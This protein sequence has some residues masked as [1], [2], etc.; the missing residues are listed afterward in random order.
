MTETIRV[1]WVAAPYKIHLYSS[2]ARFFPRNI[3]LKVV[4]AAMAY[5]G[6][7]PLLNRSKRYRQGIWFLPRRDLLRH[8][9]EFHPDVVFTDYPAYPSW[10]ARLYSYLSE[11]KVPLV[12]WLLGDFWTEYY[13]LLRSQ[14]LRDRPFVR[15]YLFTWATGLGLSNRVLTVC[16]WLK[17]RAEQR[18]PRKRISVQYQGVDPELWL[19]KDGT[20]YD[21]KRPAVGILQDNNIRP[22]V[23]GMLRFVEVLK[24]MPDVNFYVAGGGAYT[25]LVEKAFSGLPNAHLV[26]RVPY[27]DGVRRFY[28]SCDLYALPSGLDCCPTTLLEASLNSLP[29]VASRVGGIPELVREGETGWTV[30]N[31]RT[32]EWVAKI[33]GLLE[34]KELALRIG[35]QAKEHVLAN[36]TWKT[37]A[38]SLG[39]VFQ[40][41]LGR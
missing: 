16:E 10:Y 9:I 40:E 25:P 27:P 31:G 6:T 28:R 41:E 12:T 19:V 24:K 20:S 36:F 3:E 26:G 13:A 5:N 38:Q 15:A 23:E 32:D 11:Q 22:K 21:F 34:D 35:A 7:I 14:R 37:H 33:R 29:A 1:M 2:I 30:P 8:F 39:K 4:S 18:L 17:K